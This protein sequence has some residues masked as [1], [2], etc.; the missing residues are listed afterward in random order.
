MDKFLLIIITASGLCAAYAHVG[1]QYHF[2]YELKTMTEARSYCREKYTDLATVES[3]DD[4]KLLN[5]MADRSQV[6]YGGYNYRAWIGL[7]GD[8]N[9]WSW[10]LS[11]ES[12]YKP[13]EN[14][15]RNWHPEEPNNLGG[16]E[17]CVVMY[18]AGKWNDAPCERQYQPIC[19]NVT[20]SNVTFFPIPTSM[21]WTEAQSYCR[22]NHTDLASVRNMAENQKIKELVPAGQSRVW[23]GL[24]REPWKWVDGSSSSFRYWRQETNEPNNNL[25]N[26]ACVAAYFGDGSWEDW[27]CD[28]KRAFVCY[29]DLASEDKLQEQKD[30]LAKEEP[31]GQKVTPVFKQV[32]KVKMETQKN[33]NLNDPAVMEEMLKQLKQKLKDQGVNESVKLSWRKQADGKVFHKEEKKKTKRGPRMTRKDEL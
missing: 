9:S 3:M 31:Q 13:G 4:V 20:G 28:L 14:E 2:V 16:R 6:E 5:S 21:S 12:F 26:E 10:S 17:H 30:L 7:Y 19:S 27:P 29:R 22:E 18:A 33:L 32:I 15:L 1:R 24:S 23:I 8:M 11:D 25:K